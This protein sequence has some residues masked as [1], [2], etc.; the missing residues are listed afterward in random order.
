MP[1]FVRGDHDLD[2]QT[3]PSEGSTHLPCEFGANPFSGSE[4]ITYTNRKS[5][6]ASKTELYVVH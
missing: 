1:F 2:I 4:D 5:Q 3:R 6:T